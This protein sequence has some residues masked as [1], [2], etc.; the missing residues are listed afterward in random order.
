MVCDM[1]HLSHFTA[2]LPSF[3]R[4]TEQENVLNW[5]ISTLKVNKS[6]K[7]LAWHMQNA[8]IRIK[9]L[10]HKAA[11]DVE[12]QF[13][14]LQWFIECSESSAAHRTITDAY[15][16]LTFWIVN[17]E[18]VC[19][20]A[21]AASVDRH[22]SDFLLL[23]VIFPLS[24]FMLDTFWFTYLFYFYMRIHNV[25]DSSGFAMQDAWVIK[26]YSFRLRRSKLRSSLSVS[27]VHEHK[28]HK[29]RISWLVMPTVVFLW[30]TSSVIDL[31]VERIGHLKIMSETKWHSHSAQQINASKSEQNKSLKFIATLYY[32]LV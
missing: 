27:E 31:F 13:K 1:T 6:H 17:R 20:A 8:F 10:K 25:A 19:A 30:E 18:I 14:W 29:I 24:G 26:T 32:S 28:L 23:T 9:K 22:K 21:T 16:L 11:A 3:V 2:Q 4:C 7:C 15:F 5:I 12:R